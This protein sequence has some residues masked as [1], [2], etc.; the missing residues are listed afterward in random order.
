MDDDGHMQVAFNVLGKPDLH[1]NLDTSLTLTG[2]IQVLITKHGLEGTPED[3]CLALEASGDSRHSESGNMEYRIV[4]EKNRSEMSAAL[5]KPVHL[6]DSPKKAVQISISQ[7]EGTSEEGRKIAIHEIFSKCV[8]SKFAKESYAKEFAKELYARKGLQILTGLVSHD[9]VHECE[10]LVKILKTIIQLVDQEIVSV[11]ILIQDTQFINWISRYINSKTTEPSV[12]IECLEIL[13]ISVDG[14]DNIDSVD[15]LDRQVTLANL[16]IFFSRSEKEQLNSLKL[17][18]SLLSSVNPQRKAD[19]VKMLTE[20]LSRSMI[21]D[22]LLPVTNKS[23]RGEVDY[24][25]YMLQYHILD[26]Q[27][28]ERM[29][30]KMEANN[31]Q[32]TDKIKNLRSTALDTDVVSNNK[33]NSRFNA[34]DWAKLGFTNVK[35]PTLDF[36]EVPPGVLALDCMDYMA[37]N[38]EQHF[39]MVVLEH[40]YGSEEHE[41]PFVASSIQLVK[42]IA[43]ILGVGSAPAPIANA[44]FQ[45]MFFK[46]EYPFEEFYFNC[47]L[48]LNKTWREMRATRED[49][50]KVFDVVREQIEKALQSKPKTFDEF[51]SK[52]RSYSEIAKKWQ[53]DAQDKDPWIESKPVQVLKEHLKGEIDEL[54]QQQRYNFMVEGTRFPR[55]KKDGQ[56]LKGQYKYVKLHTNRKTI[57]AGETS[58]KNIPSIEDLEPKIQVQD[59]IEVTT[60]KDV[61]FLKDYRKEAIA[62]MAKRAICVRAESG[63]LELVAPDVKTYNY[64]LDGINILRGLP[65]T[66]KDYENE[67]KILLSMEVKLRLLDLEGIQIPE[68]PPPIPQ[69][70]PNLNFSI[71]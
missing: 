71:N 26:K 12:M 3:Y 8:H 47:M 50:T 52:V 54:V 29:F 34:H 33:N 22:H 39:K 21:I 51:K 1:T 58:E 60:G 46:C 38:H 2:V 7:L 30:T 53:K 55:H 9:R 48:I 68:T 37:R 20:K 25:L 66:S 59:I 5:G 57:Y 31:T 17:I 64:W 24:V 44:T 18:N 40:S 23:T 36:M 19:M 45:E 43:D 56:Q 49:F 70:P 28:K 16:V 63:S 62:E 41:C 14:V 69:Q 32:A 61:E 11:D 42:L 27:V 10:D 4:T 65:M 13:K 67:K 15:Y 35:D 6:K